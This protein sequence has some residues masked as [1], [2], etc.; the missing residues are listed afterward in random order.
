[1]AAGLFSE[2]VGAHAVQGC[3]EVVE[4]DCVAETFED[5]GELEMMKLL[6]RARLEDKW[7]R[8]VGVIEKLT[9]CVEQA[10][11]RDGYLPEWLDA[12]W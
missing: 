9:P 12:L 10:G 3:F 8:R 11:I 4:D 1:M 6:A 5:E 7:A 2:P